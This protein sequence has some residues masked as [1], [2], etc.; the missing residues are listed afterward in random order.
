MQ[1][2]NLDADLA[3]ML[4]RL[5]MLI[6]LPELVQLK[7]LVINDRS[8]LVRV[9][10]DGAAHVLELHSVTHKHTTRGK[11]VAETLEEARLLLV[12]GAAHEADNG[13]D[14]RRLD[15]LDALAHRR[16][17]RHLDDV[18]DADAARDLARLGAPFDRLLVVDDVVGAEL[19]QRRLLVLGARGGNDAR[20]GRLGKLQRRD[21][22]AAG[23]LREH[24]LAG[25]QR[26]VRVPVEGV[27]GRQRGAGQR[28][29]LEGGQGGRPVHEALLVEG[30]DG[31]E[32]AVKGTAEAGRVVDG[33]DG[34]AN[35]L[36]V[37]ERDDLVA[38][39]EA[40]DVPADGEDGAGAVGA[41]NDI[42]LGGKGVFTQRDDD[43]TVLLGSE[44]L[45]IRWD[46]AIRVGC[47]RN[48]R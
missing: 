13:N 12:V 22:H 17:P 45:D 7:Y 21:A 23:A 33:V 2:V 3:K 28:R 25:R 26:A 35:V 16:R 44:G 8:Q 34:P 37:E 18:V 27:P 29:G 19:P 11:Q 32:R 36:L 5:Q 4:S 10:V 31:A 38:G 43:V 14:A 46:V 39:L 6:C 42:L 15:G 48:S 24:P 20:A 47:K 9:G 1:L 30:A 40:R 41:R